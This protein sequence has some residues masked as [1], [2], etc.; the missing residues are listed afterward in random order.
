MIDVHRARFGVPCFFSRKNMIAWLTRASV[1][2][3]MM[4][5]SM[6]AL[7]HGCKVIGNKSLKGSYHGDCDEGTDLADGRGE[8]RGADRYV[9]E[10]AQGRPSGKG[11]YTYKNGARL[12][13][14]FV[15]GHAQ[16]RGVY[17]SAAGVRYEGDFTVGKLSALPPADC[18]STPGPITC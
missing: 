6:S 10:F 12:D 8:A 7:A 18:P 4:L 13:G 1:V 16:G 14:M 3:L 2:I 9:G 11:T 5:I 17:L 15:D